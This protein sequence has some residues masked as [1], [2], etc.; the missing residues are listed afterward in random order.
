[1]QDK[2]LIAQWKDELLKGFRLSTQIL[3][4]VTPK[5]CRVYGA[6][7]ETT[8][9]SK[10]PLGP[11]S[12]NGPSISPTGQCPASSAMNA[13]ASA[14]ASA[15]HAAANAKHSDSNDNLAHKSRQSSVDKE[16]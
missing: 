15:S 6:G 11:S 16:R 3:S 1:M 4:T 13:N 8:T 9:V 14:N 12:S 5:V 10:E 2:I 7:T